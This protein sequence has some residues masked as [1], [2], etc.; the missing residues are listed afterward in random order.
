VLI[1]FVDEFNYKVSILIEKL[2]KL[3]NGEQIVKLAPELNR[4]TL[5]AIARV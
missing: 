5:D 4:V 1:S 3:A 2:S